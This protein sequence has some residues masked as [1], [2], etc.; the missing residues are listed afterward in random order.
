MEGDSPGVS[1]TQ[2]TG[3]DAGGVKDYHILKCWHHWVKFF[4]FVEL[5]KLNSINGVLNNC[6]V[7]CYCH[8]IVSYYLL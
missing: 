5:N 6:E 2:G 4:S 7:N 3:R 8:E 1:K